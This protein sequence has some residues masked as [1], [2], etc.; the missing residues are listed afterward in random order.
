[1]E[2]DKRK[3]DQRY[4]QMRDDAQDW[5]PTWKDVKRW[6]NPT[7][8]FFE[9]DDIVKS[10]LIN[11]REHINNTLIRGL[12]TAAAGL[13]SGLTSPSRP[14]FQLTTGDPELGENQQVRI[15]LDDVESR[16][17]AVFAGSNIY[18]IL[19]MMYAELLQFGTA[20]SPIEEHYEKV[21]FGKIMTC[22]QY[23]L[24]V[25]SF[26]MVNTFARRMDFTVLQL[27]ETFG[28][29]ALPETIQNEYK[30]N[31]LKKMHEVRHVIEPNDSRIK[32]AYDFKGKPYRS[33][34]YLPTQDDKSVLRVSGYNEFPILTPRWEVTKTSDVYG[35]G[36]TMYAMGD[37]RS[38]QKMEMDGLV[39]LAKMVNPPVVSSGTSKNLN[40]APG[41]VNTY[42]ASQ[43]ADMSV[44]PVYQVNIDFNALS[45]NVQ[46]IEQRI[47]ETL[48][49]DLFRM[50]LNSE[51]VQPITAREVAE[52]HEE[53]M[54]NLGPV[55]ESM[56]QELH[57]PLIKRVYN[58]MMRG[59]LLPPPPPDMNAQLMKVNFISILAQAQQMVATSTIQQSLGFVGSV[60]GLF[61]EVI[62]V[63]D[64][65]EAAI[66][67]MQANGMP[68]KAIRSKEQIA[69]R[70]QQRAQAQ[71]QAEQMQYNMAMVQG[72]KTLSDAKMDSNNALT[73][74][75]GLGG[76]EE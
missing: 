40:T 1:M 73:M 17:N 9:G 3:T 49:V 74:L 52:K 26:G 37:Q 29:D 23:Y 33:V 61:P 18:K 59:G 35:I 56:N 20:A 69:A 44:K 62:D 46:R 39:G 30:S 63:V 66:D 71:Q 24:D 21:I 2:F 50:I 32:G 57:A 27:V 70:R 72:A 41:G 6:G 15:W 28:L 42:V 76:A 54:M 68:A 22:G 53:K 34:Y 7:R 10:R 25:D 43:T 47:N 48:F 36:P 38:L 31:T 65:D 45:N 67:Y 14:W 55:L 13:H 4:C 58:I 8:G 19:P 5:L 64:I 60:A 51:Q 16:I 75:T 12:R 11:H